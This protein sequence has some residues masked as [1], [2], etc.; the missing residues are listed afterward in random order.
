MNTLHECERKGPSPCDV[1]KASNPAASTATS[2]Q[3]HCP[4][5]GKSFAG[6]TSCQGTELSVQVHSCTLVSL[7]LWHHSQILSTYSA[8]SARCCLGYT[9]ANTWQRKLHDSP[10]HANSKA[11]ARLH[12]PSLAWARGSKQVPRHQSRAWVRAGS[13][14]GAG[15]RA[16]ASYGNCL[17]AAREFTLYI[18]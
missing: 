13:A 11:S 5:G 2:D 15:S 1:A 6:E 12:G 7:L 3:V 9:I 8:P 16:L 14:P 10:Q 4:P 18:S 17:Q